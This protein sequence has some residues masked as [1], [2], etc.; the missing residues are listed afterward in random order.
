MAKSQSKDYPQIITVTKIDDKTARLRLIKNIIEIEI[1]AN[2]E[3]EQ[4]TEESTTETMYEYDEV[5]YT[6]AYRTTLEQHVTDNF[7]LYYDFG[8][9]KEKDIRK[10]EIVKQ[11]A[12]LDKEVTRVEEDLIAQLQIELHPKK[13]EVMLKKQSLREEL[14]GL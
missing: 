6:T 12:E 14:A 9:Q 11:L 10:A 7:E 13:L 4:D 3:L 1:E 8:L 2:Q 5:V